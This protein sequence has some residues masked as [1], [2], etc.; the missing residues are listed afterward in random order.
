LCFCQ[1]TSLILWFRLGMIIVFNG[2]RKISEIFR[3][4]EFR[5]HVFGHRIFFFIIGKRLISNKHLLLLF[6][7][8]ADDNF[9]GTMKT[10]LVVQAN[11]S[12][13]FAPPG[14]FKSICPFDIASFPFVNSYFFFFEELKSTSF[15]SCFFFGCSK[16]YIK[17]RLLVF[18]WIRFDL[19]KNRNNEHELI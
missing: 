19:T 9:E 3:Q 18:W 1:S 17:I 15:C 13:L 6:I 10:N 2:N 7:L 4:F 5:V 16:L 12:I 8:S 14:I 11:G